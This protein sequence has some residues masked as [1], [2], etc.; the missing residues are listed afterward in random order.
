MK[1]LKL[2]AVLTVTMQVFLIM[3]NPVQAQEK[4]KKI[5]TVEIKSSLI[6]GM[7]E[8]RV[9]KGLAF[10]RGVTKVDVNLKEQIITVD[11]RTKRTSPEK[12]KEAITKLG[13]DADEMEAD[14]EAYEKLP[15]CCKRDVPP[16]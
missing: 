8:D 3:A 4:P 10:E 12:I 14:E 13:H 1:N 16:H 2:T 7:C 5:E 11:Y 6:C 9:I 15:A